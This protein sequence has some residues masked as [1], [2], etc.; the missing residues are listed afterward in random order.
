MGGARCRVLL[1]LDTGGTYTDAVLIDG[2]RVAEGPASVIGTAKA[3]TTH[4]DL[5]EGIGAAMKAVMQD[6][7]IAPRDIGLVSLS[8]TLATNALVEGRGGHAGLVMIGFDPADLQRQ[9][10]DRALAGTPLIS[11]AGGHDASGGVRAALDLAALDAALG[12]APADAYAVCSHFAVRNPAHELEAAAVLRRV[13]GK[14]VTCSHLLSARVGGP[15]RALTA[16][17]NARLTPMIDQLIRA[18]EALSAEIGIDAPHMVVR[19]DGA[20][21][22]AAFARERPIET[23]LSGPAASLVGAGWLTGL[24]DA[25]VSDI[26]GTT[27]DIAVLREGRPRLDPDGATVGGHRTMVE[28]VAMATHGLGGDSHVTFTETMTGE[29][30][31]LGPRRAMPISLLAL[32]HS[33]TVMETLARQAAAPRPD[34]LHGQF[35]LRA[36]AGEGVSGVEAEVM[37]AVGEAPMPLDRL[38]AHRKLG[39][40]ARRLE[41]GGLLRRAAL[42]PSDAAHLLGLHD[43]WDTDAAR[44]AANVMARQRRPDG[45]PLAPDAETLAA[46]IIARLT[47]LSAETVLEAAFAEDGLPP[48]LAIGPLAAAALDGKRGLVAPS[49]ALTLPLIGLGASAPTYYPAVAALMGADCKVPEHAGVANAVGAVVGGIRIALSGVVT[50]PAEGRFR[51]HLPEGPADYDAPDTAEAALL[52]ALTAKAR[53]DALAAGAE[54]VQITHHIERRE[55]VVEGRNQYI[56]AEMHVSAT[57]RPR[58]AVDAEE[59]VA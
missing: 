18:T 56:E 5:A 24:P 32:R 23:I 35:L 16:L 43:A 20:L 39:A 41:A 19:G 12:A 33:A 21:V 27:T 22:S 3:L 57:G 13:T 2:D 15:R 17:L 29:A 54:D 36:G 44:A 55:A 37:S 9:G 6:T 59:S 14:P 58:L 52:R 1:G 48:G 34:P 47:R 30:L 31:V 40:A 10:L 4:D 25:V 8:T 26:G 42:T 53:A 11:V 45:R 49:L 46:R 50:A 28:A 38:F 51:A 7:A